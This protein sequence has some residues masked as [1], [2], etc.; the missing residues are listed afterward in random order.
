MCLDIRLPSNIYRLLF[1]SKPHLRLT[2][3]YCQGV[4]DTPLSKKCSIIGRQMS[5]CRTMLRLFDDLPMLN[6]TLSYGIGSGE[7][8]TII[9]ITNLLSN[10]INTCYY[11]MEHIAWAGDQGVIALGNHT[12]NN[13]FICLVS[14]SFIPLFL[15]IANHSGKVFHIAGLLQCILP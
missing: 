12:T 10:A 3:I 14:L 9:R 8:D 1:T 15:Q 6:R 11:P 5:Y 13:V 7:K 4:R 2:F